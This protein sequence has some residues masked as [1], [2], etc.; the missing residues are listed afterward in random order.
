MSRNNMGH[1]ALYEA[2]NHDKFKATQDKQLER[3]IQSK[4]ESPTPA[5]AVQKNAWPTRPRTFQIHNGRIEAFVPHH[6]AVTVLMSLL[7]LL[8]LVFALGRWSGKR[9]AAGTMAEEN[10]KQSEIIMAKT[11]E[12][13]KTMAQISTATAVK[14]VVQLTPP[15]AVASSASA[16][17]VIVIK[18]L[19]EER[20]LD[21]VK[22][23]FDE[24][25]IATEIKSVAGSYYL[26]TKARFESVR[27]GD[28]AVMLEKIKNVGARY[29]SPPGYGSFAPKMFN[30]AY[31]KKM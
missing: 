3:A 13:A 15:Q 1:M 23:Y 5:A 14:P 31:G 19:S 4:D 29:Q 25:G 16:E 22:K 24:H 21:P 27:K 2:V 26:I 6:V 30:D 10:Q 7:L 20:N 17:Y 8:V 12:V 9:S 18:Q 28:G 11:A